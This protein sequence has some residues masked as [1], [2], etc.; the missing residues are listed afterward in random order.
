MKKLILIVIVSAGLA[1]S[2]GTLGFAEE[3]QDM[4]MGYDPQQQQQGMMGGQG[5][6]KMNPMM[7]MMRKDSV[8][9]TSDGGV[10]VLSGPRLLKYD[11]SLTLVKEVELPKGKGPGQNQNPEQAPPADANVPA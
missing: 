6:G 11:A 5:G 8:V 2:A 4:A 3:T 1:L 7:G 10:V 9:A